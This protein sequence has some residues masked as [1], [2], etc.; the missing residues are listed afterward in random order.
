MSLAR[1]DQLD[2]GP[3]TRLERVEELLRELDDHD[4]ATRALSDRAAAGLCA[5]RA[6]EM[7]AVL[8]ELT[9][10]HAADDRARGI[11]DWRTRSAVLQGTTVVRLRECLDV[12]RQAQH[13]AR[14]WYRARAMFA[15][16]AYSDRKVGHGVRGSSLSDH[17]EAAVAAL[18]S[19]EPALH[20]AA[21]L[22]A[23]HAEPG[24]RNE[25]RVAADGSLTM[26][27]DVRPTARARLMTA[28]ELGHA[29]HAIIARAAGAP[30]VPGALVGETV[31]CWAALACGR[32]WAADA[33]ERV[34]WSLALGD[35][36]VEEL[37]VSA[38]VSEFEDQMQA[39]ARRGAPWRASDAD[40]VWYELLGGLYG[41]TIQLPR[42]AAS[43]WSRLTSLA[44]DPAY[45]L[46]YV[47]ATLLAL[48]MPPDVQVAALL[49]RG[50]CDAD[51]LP[52][53][54]GIARVD[55]PQGGVEALE[56]TIDGLIRALGAG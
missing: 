29:V 56:T 41:D 17:V 33:D 55:W 4:A 35:H 42:W 7:A 5:A 46:S 27:I 15:G 32:R 16:T 45:A 10:G 22:A 6:T 1:L 26:V 36:L 20:G 51:E 50:A 11:D 2:H 30:D 14:N 43:G 37:F 54:L 38:L 31:A 25:V 12:V 8:G 18:A 40:A 28:H 34:A 19:H 39:S 53:L 3:A 21:E 48:A 52:A 47:W 13:I 23:S 24:P 49:A 9:V 44:T